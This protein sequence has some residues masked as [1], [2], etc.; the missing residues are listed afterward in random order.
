MSPREIDHHVAAEELGRPW[1]PGSPAEV[2][3]TCLECGWTMVVQAG[4]EKKVSE[5]ATEHIEGST[6]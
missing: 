6:E 1:P 4:V 5:W 3:L 2:R